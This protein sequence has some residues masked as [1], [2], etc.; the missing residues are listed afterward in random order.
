MM[1]GIAGNRAGSISQ[2]VVSEVSRQLIRLLKDFLPQIIKIFKLATVAELTG[3]FHRQSE[4]V[5]RMPSSW[6]NFR[7]G[8]SRT[9][10]TIA[11]SITSDDIE[12]LQRK[13]RR[14]HLRMAR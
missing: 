10:G 2:Q 7:G 13:S 12:T 11:V 8:I 1:I 4:F 5:F 9:Q 6:K 3:A 14:V